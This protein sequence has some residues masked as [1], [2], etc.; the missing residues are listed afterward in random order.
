MHIDEDKKFDKR[1]IA[2]NIKSGIITQKDYET[3][4]SKLPDVSNKLFNPEETST[5]SGEV[6]P[7]EVSE[8]SSKKKGIKKKAKGKGK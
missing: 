7:R 4:V 2:K 8:T 1:N 3:F 6:E 5:D